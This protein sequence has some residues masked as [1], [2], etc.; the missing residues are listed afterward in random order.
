MVGLD[1]AARLRANDG[2]HSARRA[3]A[4]VSM[5]AAYLG[6][7]GRNQ[8]VRRALPFRAVGPDHSRGG[9]SFDAAVGWQTCRAAGCVLYRALGFSYPLVAGNAHVRDGGL[10]CGPRLLRLSPPERTSVAL[11]AVADRGGRGRC[12]D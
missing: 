2:D 6:P 3:P 5:G 11:V 10:R 12:P 7:V 9:L 4:V 1:G 8:R